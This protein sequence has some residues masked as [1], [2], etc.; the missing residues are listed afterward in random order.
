ME[1]VE[2]KILQGERCPRIS[3]NDLVQ[4]VHEKPNEVAVL[5]L[6][7]I[8]EFNRA[9]LKG[10]INIPFSSISLGDV[11]LEALNV[12][13]LETRLANRNVVIVNN[14]HENSVLVRNLTI[15]FR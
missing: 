2:L 10:S 13:D 8:L 14:E 5:D 9:R 7:N 3:A 11:R 1:D 12:P 4:L 15:T 6:R